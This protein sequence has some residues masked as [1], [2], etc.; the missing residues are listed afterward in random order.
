MVGITALDNELLPC[1]LLGL[2]LIRRIQ[3]VSFYPLTNILLLLASL[4]PLFVRDGLT[5]VVPSSTILTF[6]FDDKI[7]NF[8]LVWFSNNVSSSNLQAMVNKDFQ[9]T[10][11]N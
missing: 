10:F 11:G 8:G 5:K 3:G 2:G 1:F 9:A 4:S 6:H 7:N